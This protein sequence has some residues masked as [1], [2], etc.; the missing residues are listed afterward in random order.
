MAPARS[1]MAR[2]SGELRIA[3]AFKSEPP[4]AINFHLKRHDLVRACKQK[5]REWY[6][7]V[8]IVRKMNKELTVTNGLK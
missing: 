7:L 5:G 1:E 2:I 6:I 3:T 8:K 4:P